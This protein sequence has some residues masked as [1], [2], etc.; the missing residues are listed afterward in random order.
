MSNRRPSARAPGRRRR[1]LDLPQPV[2]PAADV[3]QVVAMQQA[4][5]DGRRRNLIAYGHLLRAMEPP[6]TA[7]QW[8]WGERGFS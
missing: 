7:R 2:A 4:V 6:P 8:T 3:E 5:E 1:S